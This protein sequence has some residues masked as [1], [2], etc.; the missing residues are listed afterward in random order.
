MA[1]QINLLPTPPKPP[2]VSARNAALLL[3]AWGLLLAFQGWLGARAV[4]AAQLAAESG[5]RNLQERQQLQTALQKKLGTD[6]PTND[7]AA[8]IAALE[9]RTR[10]SRDLLARLKNGELGSLE[11]YG[12]QLT[13]FAR[14]PA[15]GI[16]VTTITVSDAGRALRVEGRALHK[17]Q[18]LP[19]AA[20]LNRAMRKY[21]IVLKDVE[22][23]PQKSVVDADAPADRV[24]TFKLY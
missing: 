20:A 23:A 22:I 19:Y 3:A 16:W 5:A 15:P 6:G 7:V 2:L 10:V 12:A 11:G 24:W 17:E 18:V 14:V 9:P 4:D 8:Q 13:E 21:G 1:R